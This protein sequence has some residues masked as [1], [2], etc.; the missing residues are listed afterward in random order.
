MIVAG[1]SGGGVGT[2]LP[3]TTQRPSAPIAP[4]LGPIARGINPGS[5]PGTPGANRAPAPGGDPTAPFTGMPG[6]AS[7]PFT[8][9]GSTT[10]TPPA[11]SRPAVVTVTP[12]GGGRFSPG[13]DNSRL[14]PTPGSAQA[15][16]TSPPKIQV[17]TGGS[18]TIVP[19]TAVQKTGL[20]P[21]G[22]SPLPISGSQTRPNGALPGAP[23]S[24]SSPTAGGASVPVNVSSSSPSS[25]SSLASNP[26]VVGLA[27]VAIAYLATHGKL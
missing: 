25:G 11:T 15:T 2:A 27:A 24:V 26:V 5:S 7:A 1:Q 4:G 23:S 20:N 17:T 8:G 12:L 13:G 10:S 16:S 9:S 6:G 21:A 18:G 19:G 3:S 22:F 14:E